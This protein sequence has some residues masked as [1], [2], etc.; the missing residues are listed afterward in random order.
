M[1]ILRFLILLIPFFTGIASAQ[2]CNTDADTDCDGLVNMSELTG[3]ID[4]WYGC[5]SCAP[6]LLEAIT[7]YYYTIC[8]N[9]TGCSAA[10]IFCDGGVPFN[11]TPGGYGC[12]ERA[13][14]TVCGTTELCMNG[15]CIS[16]DNMTCSVYGSQAGCTENL[17]NL[18]GCAWTEAGCTYEAS[19]SC[20][21]GECSANE[22]IESCRVDCQFE[23]LEMQ[24]DYINRYTRIDISYVGDDDAAYMGK[25]ALIVLSIPGTSVYKKASTIYSGSALYSLPFSESDLDQ[26]FL[27]YPDGRAPYNFTYGVSNESFPAGNESRYDKVYISKGSMRFLRLSDNHTYQIGVF[28]VVPLGV[29]LSIL[30]LCF[31]KD[32]TWGGEGY[33]PRGAYGNCT[34]K[35][36]WGSFEKNITTT[37]IPLEPVLFSDDPYTLFEN[38]TS[39]SNKGEN[40]SGSIRV[41][42]MRH[43]GQFWEDLLSSHSIN[44]TRLKKNP[45]FN[46]TFLGF[47]EKNNTLNS[48]THSLVKSFFREAVD[49]SNISPDDFD[50]MIYILYIPEPIN[51]P[52]FTRSFA[53]NLDSYISFPLYTTEVVFNK[54]FVSI[55]HEMGHQLFQAQDLY[56]GFGIKYPQGVPDPMHFPQTK[57]CIMAGSFGYINVSATLASKYETEDYD[58]EEQALGI[59]RFHTEDPANLV[60]CN[61]T[62]TLIGAG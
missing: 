5:S 25:Q 7:A 21:D 33:V 6:S 34:A 20:S 29:N 31:V 35:W 8:A 14:G 52:H 13:N 24:Y 4:V 28:Q 22:T 19:P 58:D 57:A 15:S 36:D 60:L 30:N 10:G 37:S 23:L 50:F 61:A 12:L 17:C 44:N 53:S 18:T 39:E 9:D 38:L 26:I 45:S 1:N 16:C 27:Q 47:A 40:K 11:C 49:E 54:G 59:G 62:V 32:D 51:G 55:A 2:P 42:S 43:I 48:S 41:Y 56:E 46:L 3:Y